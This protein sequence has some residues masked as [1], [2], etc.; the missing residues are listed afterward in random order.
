MKEYSNTRRAFSHF[1]IYFLGF[2]FFLHASFIDKAKNV[3]ILVVCTFDI[4]LH[5]FLLIFFAAAAALADLLYIGCKIYR[6]GVANG[7]F[8]F[9]LLSH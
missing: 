6:R 3:K 4:C 5:L 9:H 1:F 2:I 7:Q 8:H